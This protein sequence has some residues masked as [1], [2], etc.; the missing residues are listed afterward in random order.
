MT[1]R[2]EAIEAEIA[3]AA[4]GLRRCGCARGLRE[5]AA[6]AL[7]GGGKR[8]RPQVCLAVAEACG[9]K[10]E[11]AMHAA[12]AIEL[13][14][15]YTLIH[16]DLPAMDGDRERRGKPS[17]W[18][19][20]GEDVAILA[21]DMLQAMAFERVLRSKRF[22]PQLA[23]ELARAA[24]DV[25]AGQAEE[26]ENPANTVCIYENKTAALFRAAAAMGAI[27]AGAETAVCAAAARFGLA[28][29]MAFQFRDDLLDGNTE[30]AEETLE[31]EVRKYTDD[32]LLALKELPGDAAFLENLARSLADRKS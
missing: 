6:Y 11:D 17:V 19:K 4:E 13:L 27:A 20:Y 26:S 7:E 32:A 10:A 8:I 2:L 21:G 28:L 5:A 18:A 12:L 23:G 15:N 30:L 16:D 31:S 29:G 3:K 22:S 9:G 24:V 14:H 25:V 1:G